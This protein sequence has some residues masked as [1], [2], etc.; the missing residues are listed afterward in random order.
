MRLAPTVLLLCLAAHAQSPEVLR[1]IEESTAQSDQQHYTE[2]AKLAEQAVELSR[3]ASDKKAEAMSLNRLSSVYFYARKLEAAVDAARRAMSAASEAGDQALS[4]KALGM[5]ADGLRDQG[6]LEEA[7][8]SYERQL[9]SIQSAGDRKAEAVNLRMTAILYRQMGDQTRAMGLITKALAI[10]RELKDPAV[11]GPS[12]FILGVL[13]NEQKLYDSA[14]GHFNAALQTPGLNAGL[15]GQ[16]LLGI[17]TAHCNLEHYDRCIEFYRQQ[18]DTAIASGNQYQIAWGYFKLGLPQALSGDYAGG[19]E[20]NLKALQYLRGTDHDPYEEWHFLAA[21]GQALRHLDRERE[22]ISYYQEAIAIVERL[23]QGLVPT[24]EGMAKAASAGLTRQLFDDAISLLFSQDPAQAFQTSELARARAFLSILA[25]SKVDLRQGLSPSERERENAVFARIAGIQKDLWRNGL[26]DAGR[27]QESAELESAEKDLE[28]LRLEIR[29]S[30]PRLAAIQYPKPLSLEQVQKEVLKPGATLIEFSLG[31]E[32]SFVWAVS[33]ERVMSAILPPSAEIEKLVAAFRKSTRS[34][35]SG[36]TAQHAENETARLSGQLYRQLLKP[37]EAILEGSRSLIVVPDGV[38]YYVPFEA[39]SPTGRTGYLLE[40]FPVSY[41]P[42]A[43]SLAAAEG[44]RHSAGKLLLAF[45]DPVYARQAAAGE[46]GPDLAALPYTRD[47]V[48]GIAAL[49]PKEKRTVYLGAAA[50]E[51]TVK[52]EALDGYRYIHFATHGILDEQ[53]PARSGLALSAS[54]GKEDG[55]LQVSEIADLRL[56]AELVT[57]SACST[58]LG[59]LVSGEGML[60]LVRAFLYAGAS[61]VAVSL[62]NVNDA[63]TATLMKDFYRGLSRGVP[64]DEALRRAKIELLRQG[65]T[66]WRHPHYWAAFVLWL[67]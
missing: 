37:V 31:P 23:R 1:L 39:L 34:P 49:F 17:G 46:R 4:T 41:A 63:A 22:A 57:L 64:G 21:V 38:L 6:K 40:R 35:V 50:R 45:G 48:N 58:G 65:D 66:P 61:S 3:A 20:S 28:S 16:I 8:Q 25:E 62:W 14:L 15:R 18:L 59:E 67:R 30:N 5:V 9:E 43:T 42:S 29:H 11:E 36:L 32:H 52:G 26:T 24:E 56:D 53:H 12:L 19:Y 2:A 33:R 10:A 55:I 44:P 47:E 7:R 51:E 27:K 13:E 60:G 54:S